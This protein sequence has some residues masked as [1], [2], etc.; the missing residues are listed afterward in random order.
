MNNNLIYI[1]RTIG[2]ISEAIDFESKEVLVHITDLYGCLEVQYNIYKILLRL[3][4]IVNKN[5]I[6]IEGYDGFF[7]CSWIPKNK[8]ENYMDDGHITGTIYYSVK[9]GEPIFGVENKKLFD[10]NEKT[11]KR[12]NS[13]QNE[14][15]N[16]LPK[17]SK[18]LTK[19]KDYRQSFMSDDTEFDHLL[20]DYRDNKLKTRDFNQILYNNAVN[21]KI[22]VKKYPNFY[23]YYINR[24]INNENINIVE[25]LNE[26]KKLIWQILYKIDDGQYENE[27]LHILG[28][29]LY[30]VEYFL[31]RGITQADYNFVSE[32][33][34]KFYYLWER[35]TRDRTYLPKLREYIDL[36]SSYHTTVIKRSESFLEKIFP[37]SNLSLSNTIAGQSKIN[38]ILNRNVLAGSNKIARQLLKPERQI[39]ILITGGF[40]S[41]RI[42]QILREKQISHMVIIPNITEDVVRPS[43][44][45]Y[46]TKQKIDMLKK[47]YR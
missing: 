31:K 21:K 30:R 6:Y 18:I 11:F 27:V 45:I 13:K 47:D 7:D 34:N 23:K 15:L 2:S 42:T 41:Y 28:E 29:F 8:I 26:E 14:I 43:P 3:K 17:L 44:T 12:V 16:I 46:D 1:P 4:N 9:E 37:G 40:H 38:E 33:I 39:K 22:N 36:L 20:K 10:Q 19:L 5:S 25:L 24:M 35:H 32:Y